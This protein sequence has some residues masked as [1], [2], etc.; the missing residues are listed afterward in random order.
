MAIL[1][2]LRWKQTNRQRAW[3]H[4]ESTFAFALLMDLNLKDGN[5]WS[6]V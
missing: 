1:K 5:V 4:W 3:C 2:I 6:H